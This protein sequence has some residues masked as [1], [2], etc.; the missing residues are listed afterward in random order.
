MCVHDDIL[1]FYARA[2]HSHAE[3]W[4]THF[5]PNDYK[6]RCTLD[7]AQS[8]RIDHDEQ[9]VYVGDGFGVKAFDMNGNGLRDWSIRDCCHGILIHKDQI[10]FTCCGDKQMHFCNK[11][12]GKKI[13]ESIEIGHIPPEDDIRFKPEDKTIIPMDLAMLGEM[14]VFTQMRRNTVTLMT[15]HDKRIVFSFDTSG[16]EN[17]LKEDT[18]DACGVGPHH[19][20]IHVCALGRGEML[21][22]YTK[23]SV[24]LHHVKFRQPLARAFLAGLHPRCGA[25]SI[26]TRVSQRSS[27]FDFQTL[28]LPLRLAGALFNLK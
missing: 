22:G 3:V 28:R 15:R 12:Q 5:R 27:M 2:P 4:D 7:G 16:S 10:I 11:H 20:E 6:R 19:W 24:V 13:P 23:P 21:I 14:I 9:E 8:I 17:E 25:R 1:V 26:L 18:Y